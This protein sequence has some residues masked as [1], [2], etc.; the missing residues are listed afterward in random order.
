M[1]NKFDPRT[2]FAVKIVSPMFNCDKKDMEFDEAWALANEA[3]EKNKDFPKFHGQLQ[4]CLNSFGYSGWGN[5]EWDISIDARIPRIIGEEKHLCKRRAGS[6]LGAKIAGEHD[7]WDKIGDDL[8]CSFCG[9]LH[10]DRVLELV[11][12]HGPQII[13][14]STKD[15][16][17]Y[18][19]QPHIM[20]AGFGGI[21]Y[22]RHHDTKE[23]IDELNKL[24]NASRSKKE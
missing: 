20:N 17:W 2:R 7:T 15:Y 1:K 3:L 13:E 14:P 11:K 5:G 12:E 4:D 18:I 6:P 16:K 23:F 21:K 8:C 19:R 9:S 22:Y 24:L 10:P